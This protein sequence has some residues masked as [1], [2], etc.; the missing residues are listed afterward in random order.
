MSLDRG[1]GKVHCFTCG[2]DYDTFDLI[3]NEYGL[4]D[5]GAI[6]DKAYELYGI[7]IEGATMQRTQATTRSAAAP[8]RPAQPAA[9]APAAKPQQTKADYTAYFEEMN[10]HITETDYPQR[11]GLTEATISRFKLGFD[12]AFNTGGGIWQALIIP[13]G[14]GQFVARNTD[15]KAGKDDRVRKRGP[16][17][18]FNLEAVLQQQDKPVF[19]VEGEIDALSVIEAGGE[20]VGLGGTQGAGKLLKAL[21]G[22]KPTKPLLI[23][24]D[25]DEPGKEAQTALTEGLKVRGIPFIP[26][27]INGTH[28]DANEALTADRT[29]FAQA[30]G[31]AISAAA[32]ADEAERREYLETSAAGRIGD[33]LSGINENADTPCISTGF[34]KLDITL[35]G[36]LYEGLYIIGAISSLGKT[37]LALQ[38]ADNIAESGRDVLI[39][40]LEMARAEL[41]AKS[42]SRL[43]LTHCLENN[44]PP[45]FAKTNRGITSGRRYDFYTEKDFEVMA[46]AVAAYEAYAQHIF[47]S[48][49][50]GDIGTAEIRATIE[51]HKRITGNMPVVVIDYLQIIAPYNDRATD[52]QNTDKAVL[53]LKRMSRDYKTP[54]I[55]ISSFNRANYGEA[56]NMTAFKE[57]GAIEYSSDVLLGLQLAGAGANGFNVDIEKA[58]EPREIEIKIL[59][60]RNGP[61]GG[62]VKLDY[63]PKYNYFKENEKR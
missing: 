48:Q 23:C 43:T 55:G 63:Y 8:A 13:T 21:D 62:T 61:T 53:E 27:D 14:K 56:V 37:T 24:L 12:R 47:I 2:A 10:R 38:M 15:T 25:N 18:V 9:P 29:A 16:S 31:D 57:S 5:Y 3:G 54:V 41:M 4:T 28:K 33:F 1:R 22:A 51:K 6:F 52:K 49:G 17:A 34:D 58:K 44:I 20:A 32:Q 39:F 45:N 60:S 19:V 46:D 30:V 50:V 35:D 7:E 42:I 26:V 11:R 36:G 40:S 59:K